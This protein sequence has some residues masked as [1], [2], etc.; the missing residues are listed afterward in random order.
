MISVS[1]TGSRAI[2]L[3]DAKPPGTRTRTETCISTRIWCRVWLIPAAVKRVQNG[4]NPEFAPGDMHKR[5]CFVVLE[6]GADKVAITK[7]I[8]EMPGYFAPYDTTVNFITQEELDTKYAGFPHDGLVAAASVT[9]KGNPARIEYRCV[10]GSNPEATGNVLVAHA[11]AAARLAREGCSGAFTILDI[12][13]SYFSPVGREE[14]L[15]KFM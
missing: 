1:A 11:R 8:M 5:E 2:T 4:E 12:P 10:W 7:A 9:G 13:A 6:E 3:P 14:L 15:A